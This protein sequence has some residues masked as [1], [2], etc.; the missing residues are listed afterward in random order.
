MKLYGYWRSSSSWRVRAALAFKAVEYDY[1]AVHLVKDGGQQHSEVYR[2]LNPMEQVP[3]LEIEVAGQV[4]RIA[5]SMAILEYLEEAYP[6]PALLPAAP[7]ERARAR[8]LAEIVNSGIQPLQNLT[9]I[10]KLRDELG[11][12]A[13]AWCQEW[14]RRGLAAYEAQVEETYGGFSVGSD[15]SIADL[16]LVPQL[17]NARRFEVDL[18]PFALVR[19]IEEACLKLEAFQR[20]HPDRQ[21]DAAP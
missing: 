15:P 7:F 21:P 1:V 3:L 16:C 18:G 13:K 8:Q 19:R 6:S 5:Q 12:D 4:R 10:Q 20:S 11:L 14:I 2:A 9:V 17:Y